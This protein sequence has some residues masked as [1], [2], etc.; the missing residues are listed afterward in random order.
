MAAIVA[1]AVARLKDDVQR[2]L[3]VEFL[4]L[5]ALELGLC[6][7]QTTLALPNLVALFA[8]QILSGNLSMPELVRLTDS[9][10]TA[11]AFCTARRRL[12]LELLQELLRRVCAL[13]DQTVRNTAAMLW[14]GHRLWQVRSGFP[15]VQ[16]AAQ[17]A[18]GRSS[19]VRRPAGLHRGA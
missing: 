3:S 16:A 1:K 10:F 13:G 7:R 12:P 4:T 8:R 2:F 6:W 11:E 5:L 9:R 14:K 15:L 17:T 18:L 19:V